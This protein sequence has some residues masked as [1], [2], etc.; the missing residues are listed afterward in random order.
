MRDKD[1][2]LDDAEA[3]PS[4]EVASARLGRMLRADPGRLRRRSIS[5]GMTANDAEDAAQNAALRAWRALRTLRS[6]DEGPM[7][8]WLDVVV[9]TTVI[10]MQRARKSDLGEV[11]CERLESGHDV[12]R[13]AEVHD[14]LLSAIS[15]IDHLSPELRTPLVMSVFDELS[16]LEIAEKL[17]ITPAAVRQRISRARKA[18]R[19]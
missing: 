1:A 8:A 17:G 4:V 10:D 18:L 14:E 15:A 6:T 2:N 9:R 5:L 19:S 16:A 11:M 3:R 7:C 12:E 13:D